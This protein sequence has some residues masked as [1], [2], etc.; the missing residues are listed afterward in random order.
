MAGAGAV[1]A[2]AAGHRTPATARARPGQTVATA[3]SGGRLLVGI[4]LPAERN[5][6]VL[7]RLE[8]GGRVRLAHERAAAIAQPQRTYGEATAVEA[9]RRVDLDDFRHEPGP[10]QLA[11]EDD[12]IDVA[13]DHVAQ[14]AF[15][16]RQRRVAGG[17]EQ[18]LQ[19]VSRRP[20][21]NGGDRAAVA[22]FTRGKQRV[23]FAAAAFTD[24]DAAGLAAQ[25]VVLEQLAERDRARAVGAMIPTLPALD[26]S[27]QAVQLQL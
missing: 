19:R 13:P 20:G 25:G 16:R 24:Q 4:D 12:D 10:V 2:T 1:D 22:C 5:L 14:D 7:E 27:Q 26:S 21:V 15:A 18:S 6:L 9:A 23:R 11:Q 8:Q 3:C 17:G